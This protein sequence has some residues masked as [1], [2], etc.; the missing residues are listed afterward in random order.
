MVRHRKGHGA[1]ERKRYNAPWSASRWLNEF[2][3]IQDQILAEASW[4]PE[5]RFARIIGNGK[6]GSIVEPATK[7]SSVVV[8]PAVPTH[9]A[10]LLK[11]AVRARPSKGS[12]ARCPSA[13]R[14]EGGYTYNNSVTELNERIGRNGWGI[15]MGVSSLLA[16]VTLSGVHRVQDGGRCWWETLRRLLAPVSPHQVQ[17]VHIVTVVPQSLGHNP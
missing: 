3:C 11:A 13:P 10:S 5:E 6:G 4:N 1:E 2:I 9:V 14:T 12:L 16:V 15:R 17:K 7:A 8:G